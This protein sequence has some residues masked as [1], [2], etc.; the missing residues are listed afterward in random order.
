MMGIKEGQVFSGIDA[1]SFG[2]AF[3]KKVE[4]RKVRIDRVYKRMGADERSFA[5]TFLGNTPRQKDFEF[6]FNEFEGLVKLLKE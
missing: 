6:N 1:S 5:C 4:G 2:S 3:K